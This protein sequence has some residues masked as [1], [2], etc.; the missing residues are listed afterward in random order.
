MV[1]RL[2]KI[3]AIAIANQELMDSKTRVIQRGIPLECDRA[4]LHWELAVAAKEHLMCEHVVLHEIVSPWNV[5]S[6]L[7]LENKFQELPISVGVVGAVSSSGNSV[8]SEVG[9]MSIVFS[10][11]GASHLLCLLMP[12]RLTMAKCK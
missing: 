5:L 12:I 10:H 6:Y 9:S 1:Q 4:R 2:A 11:I 8:M 7:D 3:V